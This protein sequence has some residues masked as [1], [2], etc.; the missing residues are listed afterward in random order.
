M[1]TVYPNSN[2]DEKTL[3]DWLYMK[4]NESNT[5]LATSQQKE[6]KADLKT[7]SY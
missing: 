6:T 4:E 2:I 7:P 5:E 3:N 1:K